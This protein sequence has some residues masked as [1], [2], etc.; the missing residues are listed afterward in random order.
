M[1]S[2]IQLLLVLLFFAGCGK[3]E[4]KTPQETT[5]TE[6]TA[7]SPAELGKEIFEGKG[8]CFA[9]HMTDQK[10][11]GPSIIE[12]AHSYR[13]KQ[14]D[15]VEFLKGNAK[16]IVDPSQ[17]EVMKANLEITKSMTNDEL[18]SL[19]AYIFSFLK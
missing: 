2:A 1:K 16:P 5:N 15:I 17:F 13:Q 14:G 10:V 18:N 19:Q 6:E 12:I 9:C 7:A 8:N 11:V 4:E 3:K